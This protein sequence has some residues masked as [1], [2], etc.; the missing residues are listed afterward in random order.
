MPPL[1]TMNDL[2]GE[3]EP[4]CQ[5]TEACLESQYFQMAK[6]LS[7]PLNSKKRV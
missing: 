2:L 1:Y 4:L 3:P 6:F 5:K 7:I